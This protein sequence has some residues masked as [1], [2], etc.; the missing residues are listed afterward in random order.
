M[1][2]RARA[3]M[4]D[5]TLIYSTHS[6][7]CSC[8]VLLSS[9]KW[10]R[11]LWRGVGGRSGSGLAQNTS[12]NHDNSSHTKCLISPIQA[13]IEWLT[14]GACL[15]TPT[16]S[17]R[18]ALVVHCMNN[19]RNLLFLSSCAARNK[20][21]D[22][23]GLSTDAEMSTRAL[24]HTY[25]YNQVRFAFSCSCI[26]HCTAKEGKCNLTEC[27]TKCRVPSSHARTVIGVALQ[28]SLTAHPE[29]VQLKR[30]WHYKRLL[31]HFRWLYV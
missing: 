3:F 27:T 15:A 21:G 5:E 20:V 8:W 19:E 10:R 1:F 12:R 22:P 30:K 13:G 18:E 9:C 4:A 14:M 17:H 24:I 29:R 7:I 26:A 16:P 2:W 23:R 25:I 31:Q 28:C 6:F 11:H